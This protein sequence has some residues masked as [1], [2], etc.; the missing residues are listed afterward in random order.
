MSR[1]GGRVSRR[2]VVPQPSG[3]RPGPGGPAKAWATDSQ[4]CARSPATSSP[5]SATFFLWVTTRQKSRALPLT[6]ASDASVDARPVAGDP[7]PL[8]PVGGR[9]DYLDGTGRD[10]PPRTA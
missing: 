6:D 4:S 7:S 1:D 10:V 3:G 5:V 8:T 2:L 9:Q